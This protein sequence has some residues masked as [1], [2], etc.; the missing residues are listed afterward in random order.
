MSHRD[1]N[2]RPSWRSDWLAGDASGGTGSAVIGD[3]TIQNADISIS[4]VSVLAAKLES[5][6]LNALA[7]DKLTSSDV[8]EMLRLNREI[9][10]KLG[11][12][13]NALGDDG[14][15]RV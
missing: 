8:R 7:A 5:K 9:H 12:L 11:Y 1:M 13:Y 15:T 10:A 6:C 14:E 2:A 3:M 4:N